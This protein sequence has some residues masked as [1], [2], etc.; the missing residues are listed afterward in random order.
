MRYD[1]LTLPVEIAKERST[2]FSA[3]NEARADPIVPFTAL[4]AGAIDPEVETQF[5]RRFA[6]QPQNW[7]MEGT[8]EALTGR[9]PLG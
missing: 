6:A 9:A 7:E 1:C 2:L 5:R 3:V 8:G 4:D